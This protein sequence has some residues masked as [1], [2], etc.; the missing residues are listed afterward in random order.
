MFRAFRAG[1]RSV[2]TSR[3]K[4]E[5]VPEDLTA[6]LRWLEPIFRAEGSIDEAINEAAEKPPAGGAAASRASK[7]LQDASLQRFLAE[8]L[9]TSRADARSAHRAAV[10]L[11]SLDRGS[12]VSAELRRAAHRRIP[13]NIRMFQD[14]EDLEAEV[15][16]R[17]W[18]KAPPFTSD[19]DGWLKLKAWLRTVARNIVIDWTRAAAPASTQT[20]GREAETPASPDLPNALTP[21]RAAAA[22]GRVRDAL[23]RRFRGQDSRILDGALD[24]VFG[25]SGAAQIL[26]RLHSEGLAI[27]RSAF[28]QIVHRMRSRLEET[29]GPE[30]AQRHPKRPGRTS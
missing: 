27:R 20:L 17:L 3:R 24:V 23:F 29:L 25:L 21:E 9:R 28:D 12:S 4:D 30:R 22:R 1:T 2:S 7:R 14:E 11:L 16:A 26:D 15:L 6:V 18:S 5:S 10:L 13:D 8:H 19:A